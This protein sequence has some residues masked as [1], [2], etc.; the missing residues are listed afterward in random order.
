LLKHG[1]RTPKQKLHKLIGMIWNEEIMCPVYKKGDR[2]NCNNCRP[3]TLSNIVYKI[4]AVL[5]NKIL[6]ENIQNKLEGNQMGF[7]QI[8][9]L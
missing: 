2:L 7:R 8:D 4:F 5:L 6:I 3:I 1:G 9:L